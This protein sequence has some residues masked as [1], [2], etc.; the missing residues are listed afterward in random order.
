MISSVLS[1]PTTIA[2]SATSA[3]HNQI[4]SKAKPNSAHKLANN[5]IAKKQAIVIGAGL[6]GLN[7][8]RIL[9]NS[10]LDTLVLEAKSYA[11]GRTMTWRDGGGQ[12]INMGGVEIGDRYDRF[13]Q[14][15]KSHNLTLV[16][17]DESAKGLA[18]YR[19]G[20]L[21]NRDDW[22]TSS[23]NPLPD[24]LKSIA[25]NRL[26]FGLHAKALPL[27]S[28]SDWALPDYAE[29]DI[30]EQVRLKELGADEA[31]LAL[32]NRAGN[33]NQVDQVSSLHVMR[34]LANYKFGKSKSVKKLEGGNDL[35]AK[36]MAGSLNDVRYDHSVTAIEQINDG[37]EVHCA[38]GQLFKANNV[39]IAIPF[40]V[41]RT[42]DLKLKLSDQQ[43]RAVSDLPYTTISKMVAKV[44]QP[45]WEQ[46]GLPANM[47]CDSP[48]ERCF[49]TYDAR[50]NASYTFFI[51]GTGTGKVD[52]LSAPHATEWILNQLAKVRPMAA[53]AVTPLT[54]HSWGNDPYAQGAYAAFGPGQISDFANAMLRPAGNAYF[55][56]EHCSRSASGMEGA[57]E[58]GENTALTI[59]ESISE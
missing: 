7:A 11:G 12:Y 53:K 41:L 59:L 19:V 30:S 47:W 25:P 1:T 8:A 44:D 21:F 10:G 4:G 46:D 50:G 52:K 48:L 57:L 13:A 56:G 31:T 17:S 45:F 27:K 37:I 28:T 14:L 40:S 16:D 51:N 32:I 26:Q 20:K 33:F 24:T 49:L 22:S 5:T 34:A 43:Q 54:Y 39:V 36:R 6:A 55:A 2:S 35:L 29:F 23:A 15:A 9:E 3:N 18:I 58:S 42:I 38:N